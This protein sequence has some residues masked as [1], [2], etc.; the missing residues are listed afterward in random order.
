[1][2][3][4]KLEER[5]GGS[6]GHAWTLDVFR[7]NSSTL[8]HW[9]MIISRSNLTLDLASRKTLPSICQQL[10]LARRLRMLCSCPSDGSSSFRIFRTTSAIWTW[11]SKHN[12][13]IETSLTLTHLRRF[14]IL[15]RSTTRKINRQSSP[16]CVHKTS[17][18]ATNCNLIKYELNILSSQSVDDHRSWHRARTAKRYRFQATISS[19]YRSRLG[20][21]SSSEEATSHLKVQDSSA[22]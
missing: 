11:G 18:A 3:K 6:A 19:R 9:F 16:Q 15:T 1:M 4:T 14:L 20:K 21:H 7:R 17:S 2:I 22:T 8:R 13:S 10:Q 12:W 5:N